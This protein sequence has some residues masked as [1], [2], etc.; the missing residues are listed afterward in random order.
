[1]GMQG[2]RIYI[3]KH[4]LSAM[5]LVELQELAGNSLVGCGGSNPFHTLL[6]LLVDSDNCL[7][8]LYGGFYTDWENSW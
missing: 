8:C 7:R 1:M 6:H 5:L 4:C 2:F 3:E